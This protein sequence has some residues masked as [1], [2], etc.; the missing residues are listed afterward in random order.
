MM[1]EIILSNIEIIFKI[2]WSLGMLS[3]E[4]MKKI[5]NSDEGLYFMP[6]PFVYIE[7]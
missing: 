3:N 1:T 5:K 6:S 7:G 2:M 4:I